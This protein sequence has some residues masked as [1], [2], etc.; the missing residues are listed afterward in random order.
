M[1][2]SE[3]TD[4][5]PLSVRQLTAALE[6]VGEGVIVRDADLNV[7][8]LNPA[9][10]QILHI[11]EHTEIDP[12][13]LETWEIL[14]EH[15][16]PAD[17]PLRDV[18][19]S[20]VSWRDRLYE[21]RRHGRPSQWL[22]SAAAPFVLAD[23]TLGSISL[24]TDVTADHRARLD[25]E[26]S[27]L[28]F[29]LIAENANDIMW[30]ND[31]D[32]VVTWISPSITRILGWEPADLVG[33]SM[34]DVIHP[35][36]RSIA[37]RARSSALTGQRAAAEIRIQRADGTWCPIGV[38]AGPF[39]DADRRIIG[40]FATARDMTR[41]RLTQHQVEGSERRFRVLAELG[42]RLQIVEGATAVAQAGADFVANNVGDACIVSL[43]E[44]DGDVRVVAVAHPDGHAEQ[45]LC[46]LR[47]LPPVPLAA[48]LSAGVVATGRSVTYSD[49]DILD[50]AQQVL[51]PQLGD[52]RLTSVM[53]V[54]LAAYGEVIGTIAVARHEEHAPLG[55][56]DSD[57]LEEIANRMALAIHDGILRDRVAEAERQFRLIAHNVS[58][59][60]IQVD[61]AGIVE[62]ISPS[63][64]DRYGWEPADLAGRSFFDLVDPA[65]RVDLEV[66]L[67]PGASAQERTF[68]FLHRR[69]A[70]TWVSAA[71]AGLRDEL[72]GATGMMLSLRD[73]EAEM[74]ARASLE[75]SERRFRLAMRQSPIGMALVA[76]NGRWL[77]VN[78][79]LAAMVGYDPEDLLHLT[80]QD[81]SHPADLDADLELGARLLAGEIPD[82]RVHKRY[83]RR[84]G[85]LVWIELR[86]T[87]VRSAD[88]EPLY[89]VTQ[90]IDLEATPGRGLGEPSDQRDPITGLET[91]AA[92]MR[93]LSLLMTDK[94]HPGTCV[95][96]FTCDLDGF[97]D[98]NRRLGRAAGNWILHEVADRISR[99]I[100]AGD[101]VARVGADTF[102][103]VLDALH[104]G[105][106]APRIAED[107]VALVA[108]PIEVPGAEQVQVSMCVGAAIAVTGSAPE[109]L[110]AESERLLDVA[111]TLGPGGVAVGDAPG[112]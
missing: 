61:K 94:R 22:R 87:L 55:T 59:V 63:V 36:D 10:Q 35:E 109:H 112:P 4:A 88:G 17:L 108:K 64:T 100:R 89:F 1:T 111:R 37:I 69:G 29:R 19:T 51:G 49:P 81:I 86:V 30:R 90:M 45:L 7:V 2:D 83:V 91:R 5:A 68:R 58:D 80:F 26:Q 96:L 57:L 65:Q 78:D 95:A 8:Y 33:R 46:E 47:H 66:E 53:I 60:V 93:S 44:A 103:I 102:T 97:R 27:E 92:L 70:A 62:W 84:D 40:T 107:I 42:D 79:A 50:A 28:Y 3:A 15:D 52:L 76:L 31:V 71:V 16:E 14:D 105:Q 34:V 9:A 13:P 18:V 32:G 75:T 23:G 110:V 73:S 11:R 85:S 41:E 77:E 54:P 25:A 99:R 39:L 67:T 82:Y 74:Q 20:G 38:R 72:H 6:K 104:S 12:A 43:L 101:A 56:R 98:L 24:F 21:I 106:E 48:T